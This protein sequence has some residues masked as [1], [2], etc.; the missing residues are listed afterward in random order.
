MRLYLYVIDGKPAVRTELH[1]AQASLEDHLRDRRDVSDVWWDD[2]SP[3]WARTY[4][5]GASHQEAM[6]AETASVEADISWENTD[7]VIFPVDL[8]DVMVPV[9]P[10][11]DLPGVTMSLTVVT[12]EKKAD[13]TRV[14]PKDLWDA[15]QLDHSKMIIMFAAEAA[16]G[17]A[18]AL[19]S[20]EGS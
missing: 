2:H 13:L 3:L 5:Y 12:S 6:A 14:V 9:A 17:V 10:T 19:R 11:L 7:Q 16:H 8:D 18:G 15:S 20:E 4:L 1:Q